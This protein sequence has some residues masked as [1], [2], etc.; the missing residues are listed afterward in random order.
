VKKT[1]ANSFVSGK[2]IIPG[3]KV[4]GVMPGG[5]WPRYGPVSL[6]KSFCRDNELAAAK[7]NKLR[8]RAVLFINSF[9]GYSTPHRGIAKHL[10]V[11]DVHLD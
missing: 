11:I 9:S 3:A 1:Q 4:S 8:I 5:F 7:R 6:G 2:E 10:N